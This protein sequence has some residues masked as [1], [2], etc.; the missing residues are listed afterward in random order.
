MDHFERASSQL[1]RAL[2]GQR[3]QIAFARRLGY[4]A[5]PITDWENGRRFPTIF[6]ALRAARLVG[7]D[8][9][10]AFTKLGPGSL[11]F[12]G[13]KEPQEWLSELRGSR[14]I[15]ELA[16]Q[17]G[18]S[19]YSV[20]R[21][22]SGK[23]EARL[24]DFLRLLDAVTGR[25]HEW[26]NELVAVENVPAL[27]GRFQEIQAARRLALE[28]PWSEA[29]L[30]VLETAGYRKQKKER[31]AYIAGVLGVE[32]DEVM[33]LLCELQSA[34]VIEKKR[35]AYVV[36]ENLTVDTTSTPE[37]LLGVRQHWAQVGLSRLEQMQRDDWF[38]Y[39]VIAVSEEDSKKVEKRLRAAYREVRSIVSESSPADRAA[40]LMI[41]LLRF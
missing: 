39:N 34:G 32:L 17:A 9:E 11:P 20:S 35:G 14:S 23:S 15:T 25:L 38:A 3:S 4:R 8:V 31:G 24:P 29:I 6:E 26:V 33:S 41:Q 30:R 1:L 22:L 40:V 21:Y 12:S 7:R 27:Y 19:R 36:A 28:H 37:Q 18:I 13:E 10:G 5:N 16:D 2:R